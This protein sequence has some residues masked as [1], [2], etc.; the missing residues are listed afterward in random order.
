MKI[1]T[2]RAQHGHDMYG[3]FTCEHCNKETPM[4][5]GY[6]DAYYHEEVVPA[7]HCPH[8]GKN[9]AGAQKEPVPTP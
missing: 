5:G 3:T 8:C 9:R 7:M 1:T 4:Q 2:I 6:D